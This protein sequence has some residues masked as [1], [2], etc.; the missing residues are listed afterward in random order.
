VKNETATPFADKGLATQNKL[1]ERGRDRSAACRCRL[2]RGA[3]RPRITGIA[4]DIGPAT[5]TGWM[6]PVKAGRRE[7]ASEVADDA[8]GWAG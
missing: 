1:W 3:C 6:R 5:A 4:G 8:A 7:R 2:Q